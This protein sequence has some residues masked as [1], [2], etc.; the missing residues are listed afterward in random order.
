MHSFMIDAVRE[1]VQI[2]KNSRFAGLKSPVRLMQKINQVRNEKLA[3]VRSFSTDMDYD[4][5]DLKSRVPKA[6]NIKPHEIQL[7]NLRVSLAKEI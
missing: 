3:R 5:I 2:A 4:L 1:K 7:K 6:K